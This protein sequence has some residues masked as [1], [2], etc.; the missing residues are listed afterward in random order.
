MD[1]QEW[2]DNIEGLASIYAFDIMPDGSYSE[3]RLMAFN[4]QNSF[5]T[6]MSPDA[7]KFYPGIPYRS[8]FTDLNFESFV[9]KSASTHDPLY[10]YVNA[11][12]VWLKGFY[13]PITEPGT[14]SEDVIKELSEKTDDKRTVYCLYIATFKDEVDTDYMQKHSAE[15]TNAVMDIGIKLHESN[16][17]F[18]SM[19][20]AA[21]EIKEVCG[22]EKCS[23]YT[24]DMNDCKCRFINSDGIQDTFLENLAN[25]M[26]CSPF[27]LAMKW[28]QDLAL[29]D[30]LLLDDL[31]VI[32]ERDPIWHRSLVKNGIH[33]LILYS[34]RYNQQLVGFIWAA[35]YDTT[36]KMQLKETLELT[37]F[38]LAAVITNYQLVSRLEIKST[39]DGLTQLSSRNALNDRVEDY[40]SGK[41]KLPASM[42]IA[43]ADLNG[44]KRVNDVE[45][46]DAGDK[47]LVRAAA[48]LKLAFGD[49]EI[50]RAG[51]D[52]F[53][54]FCND[55]PEEKL[56]AHIAQLRTLADST[57]DVSFA[58]G[59]VYCS[60]D[61]DLTRAMQISDE[62]MYK[63]KEEYYRQHPDKDRRK[64][65]RE[66]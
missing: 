12:G 20:D 65:S 11:R 39:V 16:D 30:C 7:P 47:L 28:E 3:I 64:S 38:L 41:E 2:I 21:A 51:G 10:S 9:Y 33:N 57:E 18:Q 48:L 58:V 26:E 5:M 56:A 23:I 17:L 27:E 55:I 52:E 6:Q 34:I 53:V 25:E 36:K 44:L 59:S 60:G 8:Y 63:D 40:L 35:N 42:G 50:Y 15:V 29:S 22:A 43:Y 24:V 62:N 31:S 66:S 37:T 4:K 13:L 54:I 32:E 45:G 49:H 19:A 14:V 1:Y 46:H 61:Y